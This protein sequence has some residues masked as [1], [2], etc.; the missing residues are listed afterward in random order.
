M[1]LQLFL[2]Y[3]FTSPPNRDTNRFRVTGAWR[4]FFHEMAVFKGYGMNKSNDQYCVTSTR[5]S[6]LVHRGRGKFPGK[7]AELPSTD[8]VE[9]RIVRPRSVAVQQFKKCFFG[10]MCAFLVP[11]VRTLALQREVLIWAKA[12]LLLIICSMQQHYISKKEQKN[13][14]TIA[15]LHIIYMNYTHFMQV[16]SLRLV[17]VLN[18]C[19]VCIIS[20]TMTAN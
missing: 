9:N 4:Q 11:R 19:T 17:L 3:R 1:C 12:V 14:N 2:H 13:R 16:E 18:I 10:N 5:C 8:P 15:L 20:D 6:L 7:C